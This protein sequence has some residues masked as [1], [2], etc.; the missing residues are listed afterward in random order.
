MSIKKI[1]NNFVD[2]FNGAGIKEKLKEDGKEIVS[3]LFSGK[4]MTSRICDGFVWTWENTDF[5]DW[6]NAAKEASDL[7]DEFIRK[8]YREKKRNHSN[9]G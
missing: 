3:D 6:H 7:Y 4:H 9:E 5:N 2:G 1:L 8:K